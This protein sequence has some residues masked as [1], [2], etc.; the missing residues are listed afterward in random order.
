MPTFPKKKKRPWIPT[1]QPA[2]IGN[3]SR[4]KT[5]SDIIKFYNS[6]RWRSL[7]GYYLQMNPLCEMC[8]R[9]GYI[10]PAEEIDHRT[11]IRLGGNRTTL[12][13]LQSLCKP[14]HARKSGREAHSYKNKK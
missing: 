10:T 9:A 12:D 6:K 1:R 11:P 5:P 3:T 14:C 8:K 13:N 2:P 4:S 7:R